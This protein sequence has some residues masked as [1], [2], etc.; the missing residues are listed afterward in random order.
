[1]DVSGR[2]FGRINPALAEW[3]DMFRGEDVSNAAAPDLSK[4]QQ[5]LFTLLVIGVYAAAILDM[6]LVQAQANTLILA[7]QGSLPPLT[8]NFVWLLG[9]SHASYLAYKAAPHGPPAGP[10]T[11][12]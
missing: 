4:I 3:L 11:G 7:P 1:M 12:T 2:V 8:A 5:F 9:I 6:F 10:V